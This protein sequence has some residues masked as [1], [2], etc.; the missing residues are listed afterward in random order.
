MGLIR[1]VSPE[2]AGRFIDR[3]VSKIEGKGFT[4][5]AVLA[6]LVGPGNIAASFG[7]GVGATAPAKVDQL[8]LA[9]Q[10]GVVFK[11]ITGGE[12]IYQGEKDNIG[13]FGIAETPFTIGQM[14][15]LLEIRGDEVRAIFTV[16]Q[17]DID[18]IIS[19]SEKTAAKDV[20]KEALDNCPLVNISKIESAGIAKLL[21]KRLLSEKEWER[22]ASGTTGLKRPWGDELDKKYAVYEDSG[23]RPVKSKLAGVSKEGV[24]DLIGNVWEWLQNA[25]LRGSSWNSLNLNPENLQAAYRL[26]IY[27][28]HR[29]YYIGL[30]LAEDI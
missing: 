8:G 22:A 4:G 18:T 30:R 7:G 3:K 10:I 12:F 24:Y 11:R 14:K 6:R 19:R 5:R 29:D 13:S 9:R 21:G 27:P 17:W 25:S 26:N 15:Q 20:G 16:P 28:E 1:V 2:A 23:T